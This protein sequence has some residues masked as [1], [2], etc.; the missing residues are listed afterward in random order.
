[1]HNGAIMPS[2]VAH[3]VD[4]DQTFPVIRLSGMLDPA[5]A[6]AVRSALLEVLAAQPE[7]L[8]VDVADLRPADRGS[9]GVLAEVAAETAEWPATRI[10]LITA[11][12]DAGWARS[13]LPHF[14]DRAA[15]LDALGPAHPDDHRE[16]ALEPVVG[17]A[18]RAR[19]LVTAS[20]DRWGHDELAGSATIV[21]TEMVNNVVAH[22]RTEMTVLLSRRDD[23]V[24]VAVRD[25]SG[26]TPRFTG[27]VAPTSYGGRGLLL[28]DSVADS[29]GSLPVPGGKIVW[30]LLS[31][32]GTG[33]PTPP[34]G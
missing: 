17:A 18:R 10:V 30:A 31:A 24:R 5:A 4:T 29:W 25:R 8:I 28:I 21:V 14:A 2:E 19:E 12:G 26:T 34:R 20:C 1:M 33:I 6:P 3:L 27:P 9:A 11:D 16:L 32:A 23:T 22:A 13:G 15:A 7:A